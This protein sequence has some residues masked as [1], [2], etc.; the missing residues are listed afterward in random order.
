MPEFLV[1]GRPGCGY[2]TAAVRLLQSK[3]LPVTYVD[4]A[5]EGISP[6]ELAARL[7]RPVRTV[8]QIL[9]GDVYV[10]GY[11]DLVPYLARLEAQA[12]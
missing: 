7:G 1:Y 8:P 6:A 5:A 11:T 2:C 4:M 3:G 9:H 12:D 10:G